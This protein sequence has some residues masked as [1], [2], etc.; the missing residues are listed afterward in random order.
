LQTYIK[1]AASLEAAFLLLTGTH[2]NNK[3]QIPA[4][5]DFNN[6]IKATILFNIINNYTL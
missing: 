6:K 2:Y 3:V 4:F 1:K 5:G